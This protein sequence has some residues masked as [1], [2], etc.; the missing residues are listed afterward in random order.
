M[1]QVCI[2]ASTGLA[3]VPP[4][5]SEYNP[6]GSICPAP[7]TGKVCPNGQVNVGGKCVAACANNEVRTPNGACCNPAEVTACGECCP[8]G[9]TAD[10]ANGSCEPLQTTQ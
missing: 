1:A 5:K 2:C 3:A 10:L 6:T 9:T 8:P 4:V 7:L